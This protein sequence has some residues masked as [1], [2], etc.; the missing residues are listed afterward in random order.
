MTAGTFLHPQSPEIPDEAKE[1]VLGLAKAES[2][3]LD[4]TAGQADAVVGPDG[5][6]YL[7]RPAQ[8]NLRRSEARLRALFAGAPDVFTELSDTG[9]VLMQSA[10]VTQVLGYEAGDLLGCSIFDFVHP[11][12]LLKFEQACF[13]AVRKRLPSTADFRHLAHDGAWLPVEATIGI[14]QTPEG[15]GLI[16]NFRGTG[17]RRLAQETRE[18]ASAGAVLDKD[19]FLAMLAHELRTPL[20]PVL[21]GVAILQK[22]Q[23]F[24]EAHPTLEMIRRNIEMQSRLIADLLD[25]VTLG[26]HKLRLR[27]EPVDA[28]EA[29]R[30]VL[31]ICQSEITAAHIQVVLDLKATESVVLG[32]SLRIQ[33]VMWNVVRNAVKFSR[34]GGRVL[35]ASANDAAGHVNFRFVDEGAGIEPEFLARVFD[36]YQ[37]GDRANPQQRGGIGLGMYIARELAE[38]QEGALDVESEGLGRGA[39]FFFSLNVLPAAEEDRPPGRNHTNPRAARPNAES[40]LLAKHQSAQAA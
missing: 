16:L 34:P 35:I 10:A 4:F 15:K 39:T 37:Q 33:Q 14:W 5:V 19:R 28:H 36:A 11:D 27:K 7:L 26:Q 30:L 24:A 9:E 32:D 6:A 12:D 17:N 20:T 2:R 23:R 25:F 13:D 29:V 38:A 40:R 1:L 22:D 21:M 8:E 18:A 31:E 3:L